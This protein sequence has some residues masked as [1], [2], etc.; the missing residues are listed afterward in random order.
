MIRDTLPGMNALLYH[1][2]YN[3]DSWMFSYFATVALS[4]LGVSAL[5]GWLL[6]SQKPV[7]FTY[8]PIML[9]LCS[10]LICDSYDLAWKFYLQR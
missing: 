1:L 9:T 6:R 4:V 7:I 8:I 3:F 5:V 2:I 10:Y